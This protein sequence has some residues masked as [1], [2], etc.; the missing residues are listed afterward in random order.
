MY[1]VYDDNGWVFTADTSIELEQSL[2]DFFEEVMGSDVHYI[3]S[4]TESD[5]H[6]RLDTGEHC[7]WIDK[8]A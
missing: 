3:L 4:A 2:Y 5:G 7:L 6:A 1:K 8:V